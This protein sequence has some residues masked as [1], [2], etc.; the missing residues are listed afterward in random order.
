MFPTRID[1][2]RSAAVFFRFALAA[3][4]GLSAC[5]DTGDGDPVP[6]PADITG[7]GTV[8]ELRQIATLSGGYAGQ[9]RIVGDGWP[10]SSS[11]QE[12]TLT[13]QMEGLAGV[14]QFELRVQPEPSS[15]FDVS[16]AVFAP[17]QPFVTPFASGIQMEGSVMR[18]GGAS[19]SGAVDGLASLGSLT[20]HTA[21]TFNNSA[22]LVVT[23]ISIGPSSS[24]RDEFTIFGPQLGIEVTPR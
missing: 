16:G 19:L 10:A 3:F 4:M 22:R 8:T 9:I 20:I 5:S 21:S 14:R 6:N 17:T 24:E 23:L 12:L 11:A 7:P 1:S 2:L 13:F 15:A 18:M